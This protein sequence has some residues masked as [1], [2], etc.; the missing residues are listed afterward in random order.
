[1][2]RLTCQRHV[3]VF[4]KP[5]LNFVK[6]DFTKPKKLNFVKPDFIKPKT[7]EFCETCMKHAIIKPRQDSS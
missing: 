5:K 6:P 1:M 3:K 2:T 4:L 7:L